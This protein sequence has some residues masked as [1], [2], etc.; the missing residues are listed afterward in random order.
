MHNIVYICGVEGS[1]WLDLPAYSAQARSRREQPSVEEIRGRST[2]FKRKLT[3][4][5]HFLI[6]CRAEKL[7]LKVL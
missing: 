2:G 4:L 7:Y 3:E 6:D 5:E 1:I